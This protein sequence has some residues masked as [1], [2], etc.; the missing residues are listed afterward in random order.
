MKLRILSVIACLLLFSCQKKPQERAD[1]ACRDR[2]Y[3]AQGFQI[4]SHA[5][6]KLVS[7]KNPWHSDIL[8]TY[9][10]VPKNRELPSELPSGTVVRTPLEKTVVFSSVVCG[11]LNE[12]N[13][14][15]SLAGVAEPEYIDIPF[16]QSGIANG[17]IQDI[18]RASQPDIEKLLLLSPE[19]LITNPVNEAGAGALG[20]LTA[21]AIP[22]L[23]WMENH[24]LGQAEWVRFLGLLFDKQAL[25]DSLFEATVHAYNELKTGTDTVSYRPTVFAEK[26]YGDFWYMPGG[27]SYFANLLHDA[28]ADYVFGD[29]T[30]AGSIPFAFETV[31]DRAGHADFWLFKYYGSQEMTYRQLASEYANYTLFDAYKKRKIYACNT[32]KTPN[33]YQNLPLHPDWV[34]RDLIAVFHPELTPEYR[35]RYYFPVTE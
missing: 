26:K 4:E 5:D 14:L 16:I 29:N 8:Q 32:F 23:E 1:Q 17:A 22:C 19:A 35:T 18:G 13:V 30:D 12:L 10:L 20:K 24:P 33:Y 28:G 27:K 21:P 15:P 2:I 11:V 25:A 3:Y 7:I 31:L 6:F 9:I 34:L